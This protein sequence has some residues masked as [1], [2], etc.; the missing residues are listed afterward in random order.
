MS[1]KT[2]LL[3][4]HGALGTQNQFSALKE[5]LAS[6]FEPFDL[7]FEGHGGNISEN[8]FSIELFTKNVEDFIL[9]NDLIGINIFGYSMGGYIALNLALRN[10]E[11][12]GKIVTLGTKFDWTPTFAAEEVKMLKP[13]LIEVKVP[14]FAEKLRGDH[15]PSDWKNVM[16]KTTDMMQRMGEGEK[17]KH[18]DFKQIN[19]EVI[20]GLGSLDTMVSSE[21]SELIVEE[22]PNA[23]LI[24]L[25]NF[26][27][28][29]EKG[30]ASVIAGFVREV[31]L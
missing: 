6:D 18:E 25:D 22:L 10:P 20:I 8:P 30:D 28:T 17:I 13:E 27:H 26:P 9:E 21:E 24:I 1:K 23:E 15:Y 14:Q 31:L 19:N 2:K 4:L 16:R 11:L 12:V 7:N 5:I 29:I 3:L